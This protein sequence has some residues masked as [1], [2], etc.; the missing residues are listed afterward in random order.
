MS[1]T[2]PVF[3]G[4]DRREPISWEVCKRSLMRH[5]SIPLHIQPL[6]RD[7]LTRAQ[8][9]RRNHEFKNGHWHD[10][11]DG[12]HSTEFSYTR[13]LV[14]ALCQWK[15]W[16]LFCD[17]DFLWRADVARLYALRREE[18]AAMVV[19]H[20][21]NPPEAS[22]MWGEEQRRYARKNWS[23]LIL[24]NCSH[25]A[26]APLTPEAVNASARGWLHGFRWLV[27]DVVG[28]FPEAW[29]WL[30]GWSEGEPNAVHFT[31]GTPEIPGYENIAYAHEWRG[32][33]N[34]IGAAA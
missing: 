32:Y 24:W 12:Q 23:S 31:R 34:G 8:V 14:P 22:K 28:G 16:A 3:I 25:E 4:Y 13:Y 10:S 1:D 9:Y 6:D 19:K 33:A 21:H 30:E 27:D 11:R 18:Y 7:A 15:G 26:N 5:A 20:R 17:A 29:N 2:L